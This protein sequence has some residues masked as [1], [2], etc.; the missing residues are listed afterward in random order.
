MLA[1]AVQL[2]LVTA[3]T[4][5]CGAAAAALEPDAKPSPGAAS[6]SRAGARYFIFTTNAPF[7]QGTGVPCHPH[8]VRRHQKWPRPYETL[9]SPTRIDP[10]TPGRNEARVRTVSPAKSGSRALAH[11]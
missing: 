2:L 1:A 6:A 4:S 9:T 8:R 3:V 5:D 10:L 7:R 11:Q